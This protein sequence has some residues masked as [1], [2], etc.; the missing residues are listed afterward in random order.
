MDIDIKCKNIPISA[1]IGGGGGYIVYQIV[2]IRDTKNVSVLAYLQ[3]LT[4]SKIHQNNTW[5]FL[6]K[7]TKTRD[8]SVQFIPI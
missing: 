4:E 6:S 1:D 8:K 3:P 2:R 5:Q 7:T